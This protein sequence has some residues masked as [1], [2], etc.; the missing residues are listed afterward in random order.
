MSQPAVHLVYFQHDL[1]IDDQPCLY[2]AVQSGFPVI[3]VYLLPKL[4]QAKTSW[5]WQKM[6][7][8]RTQFLMESLANLKSDLHA[9]QIPFMVFTDE[10]ASVAARLSQSYQIVHVHASVEPGSEEQQ[11]LDQFLLA[12]HQP[13][14]TLY[15]DK[16]L[17]HPD[18]YPWLLT[19]LPLRY[20][21]ARIRIEQRI[22]VKPCLPPLP[23]ASPI[24]TSNDDWQRFL[25]SHPPMPLFIKGG[26]KAAKMHLQD[27]FFGVKAILTYKETRNELDGFSNSSKLSPALSLGLLSPRWI[28]WQLKEVE[29]TLKKNQSTYWLWF[30]LLWRDYFYYLHLKAKDRFFMLTGMMNR[31]IPWQQHHKSIEAVL[32]G[33]TGYP[34]VDANLKELFTTGWMSNRGRQ[35]VASF[36]SKILNLDWRW[37][38]SLFE[39]YLIDYDASSNYGNWQYVSGVGVDPR[40]DRIF[41]ISLQA[42]K[43]DPLGTYVKKWLPA[44]KAIPA[45]LIYQPWRMTALEMALYQCQLPQQYPWPIVDDARVQLR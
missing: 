9:L 3:G 34:L 7:P 6:G 8:Y 15:H 2:A 40:E 32:N 29:A 35:N 36:L 28:Y 27:Y 1:R 17:L 12:L 30:E 37:G 43:Y 21:D 39:H 25:E 38:A 33:T 16:P 4:E 14:L 10:I 5:G 31:Q 13:P 22:V 20:T 41:N 45:P 18:A 11:H 26:S 23:P 19:D 44:L 24:Q 42:K